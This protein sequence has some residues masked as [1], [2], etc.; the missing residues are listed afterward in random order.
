VTTARKIR[1][2]LL[3]LA[4]F[5]V[6]VYLLR[7]I[8][9]PFV[10]GMAV[11]YFLDPS[12]DRLQRAGLSRTLS[13]VVVTIVFALVLIAALLLLVPLLQEQILQLIDRLPRY[14][15]A[16]RSALQPLI[17]EIQ[18]RVPAESLGGAQDALSGQ[19]GRV[20]AW[21]GTAIGGVVT[22]GLALVNILS[23]IFITP[24]VAFYLLRDWDRMVERVDAWLPREHAPVIREQA[25]LIDRTLAGWVRGQATVCLLLAA[26]YGI[27]L[28][29][30][31]LD[32]GLAIGILSGLLSFVPFVGTITGFV[33]GLAVA[34]AQ[35]SDWG[36]IAIVL[37]VF[38][39][40]Q[41]IE[42]NFLTP[43][44]VG[45][46]VGLHPVWVIFAL[47]A[48]GALFGFVGVLLA[49][50]AAA[51]IGVL[52]RFALSRYLDSR[53]YGHGVPAGV[54]PPAPVEGDEPPAGP[55]RP[56]A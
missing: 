32:F 4:L 34:F 43:K 55:T 28:S 52:A 30:I 48:G 17:R 15:E 24:V 11:A 25:T 22:G 29:I 13:T 37:A 56:A 18:E 33:V 35:Y 7:S 20:L 8:L 36:P 41:V 54:P 9:L 2:W 12:V 50:P 38:V 40:G 26:F 42:G 23:L 45:D 19:A 1:F 14:I 21:I 39:A 49:L 6:A 5:L 10:A 47:L 27:A 31:G 51:V 46:R 44:L 3:G 53:Y 16:L